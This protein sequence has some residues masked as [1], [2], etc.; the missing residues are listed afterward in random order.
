MK[1]ILLTLGMLTVL[2][3]AAFSYDYY[4][5]HR[6]KTLLERADRYWNAV[7]LNDLATAYGLDAE[8]ARGTLQPHEVDKGRD[9]SIRLVSFTLGEITYYDN[10]AEILLTKE[11]TWPDSKTKTH[12]KPPVKDLWTFMKGQWYHGAPE[13][14]SSSL[15]PPRV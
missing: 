12:Q 9:W 13:K 1:K 5:R 3:A 6:E 14:G 4:S 10:H 7:R 15:R 11:V 2:V 8:A